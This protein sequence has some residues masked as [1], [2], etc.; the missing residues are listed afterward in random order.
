MKN[1]IV[2]FPLLADDIQRDERSIIHGS[3]STCLD[4]RLT[5]GCSGTLE[6]RTRGGDYATAADQNFGANEAAVA[7]R[8]LGC[9]AESAQRSTTD[10]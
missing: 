5:G 2:V 4:I 3:C 1:N 7:C 6:V 9:S 8:Q 10:L